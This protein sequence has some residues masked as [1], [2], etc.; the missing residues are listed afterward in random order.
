MTSPSALTWWEEREAFVSRAAEN[1]LTVED[2]P[3]SADLLALLK[4]GR[5]HV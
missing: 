2:P 5:A 4:I 1:D 3:F